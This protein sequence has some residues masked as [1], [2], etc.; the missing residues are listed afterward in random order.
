MDLREQRGM[1]LAATRTIEQKA[2][3]WIVP[4]QAGKET[5]RVPPDAEDCMPPA[6]TTKTRE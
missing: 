3:I 5:Y 2:G 4:S 1:E 6:P